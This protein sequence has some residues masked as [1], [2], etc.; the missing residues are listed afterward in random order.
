MALDKKFDF[1]FSNSQ[2]LKSSTFDIILFYNSIWDLLNTNSKE[3]EKNLKKLEIAR[4]TL[5][6]EGFMKNDSSLE[7]HLE[8]HL[9]LYLNEYNIRRQ[10]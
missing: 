8:T 5:V 4:Q 9:E 3:N 2:L 10:N 1:N 7:E 6:D